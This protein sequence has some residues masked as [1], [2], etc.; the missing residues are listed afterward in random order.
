MGESFHRLLP[1]VPPNNADKSG[2]EFIGSK[3]SWQTLGTFNAE[4]APA[5]SYSIS[6]LI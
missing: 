3:S 2:T 4:S 6:V 1:S 5:K